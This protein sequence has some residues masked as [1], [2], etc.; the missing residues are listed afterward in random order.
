MSK[1]RKSRRRICSPYVCVTVS[2]QFNLFKQF[3]EVEGTSSRG[4]AGFV[5]LELTPRRLRETFAFV[6]LMVV[7]AV[8]IEAC[9]TRTSRLV[10]E[11]KNP[12]L[13]QYKSLLSI[14][15]NPVC[16]CSQTAF[17]VSTF[18]STNTTLDALCQFT[19]RLA[20]I[21]AAD[22]AACASSQQG[23]TNTA[24]LGE[25]ISGILSVVLELVVIVL[26][27]RLQHNV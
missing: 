15:A 3:V 25:Y 21:C 5:H 9:A 20:P 14:D 1:C 18:A 24:T 22:P 17:A 11:I 8:S 4:Y 10:E 13:L 26:L 2:N 12:T 27:R 19:Q 6:V 23:N 16:A 7:A